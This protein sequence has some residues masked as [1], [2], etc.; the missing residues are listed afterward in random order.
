LDLHDLRVRYNIVH[1]IYRAYKPVLLIPAVS[2]LI[3]LFCRCFPSFKALSRLYTLTS[4][5]SSMLPLPIIPSTLCP[6]YA[7]VVIYRESPA[8][9]KLLGGTGIGG[10]DGA[11]EKGG[12]RITFGKSPFEPL[13]PGKAFNRSFTKGGRIG[14]PEEAGP[15]LKPG[16]DFKGARRTRG[17]CL[18]GPFE[19]GE[20]SLCGV[21]F[22]VAKGKGGAFR[23]YLER[24]NAPVR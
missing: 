2:P 21:T 13:R 16:W 24:K 4:P 11:Y 14:P 7:P 6:P 12:V 18:I 1:R 3:H 22:R 19:S 17:L 23:N 10:R 20:I 9:Q 8:F 15:R 5:L